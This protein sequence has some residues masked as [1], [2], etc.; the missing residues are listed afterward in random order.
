MPL[1]TYRCPAC[2]PF[3]AK[4]GYDQSVISH[5]CG[6]DAGREGV[7]RIN[8]GGFASIPLKQAVNHNDYRRF[9][10]ASSEIDYKAS[11]LESEGAKVPELPFFRAAKREAAKMAAAGVKAE[12]I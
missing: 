2:G 4:A 3:D 10:E 7:Y 9:T 8:F 5:D 6:L 1:Y 12:D 11:R